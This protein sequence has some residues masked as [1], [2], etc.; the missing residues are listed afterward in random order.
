MI[1]RYII[2]SQST[3]HKLFNKGSTLKQLT[4]TVTKLK[5]LQTRHNLRIEKVKA[6]ANIEG[7]HKDKAVN[8][9]CEIFGVKENSENV[10]VVCP[11]LDELKQKLDYKIINMEV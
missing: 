7:N 1:S 6:H 9:N 3:I 5:D 8:S 4:R 2:D 10:I 11:R